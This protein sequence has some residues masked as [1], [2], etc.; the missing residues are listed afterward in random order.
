MLYDSCWWNPKQMHGDCG[1]FPVK[2][3]GV[4]V[5]TDFVV[6]ESPRVKGKE[7]EKD[8]L[9]LGRPF[10]RSTLMVVN[11]HTRTCTIEVQG[12]PRELKA[13][14]SPLYSISQVDSRKFIG[15]H[16]GPLYIHTYQQGRKRAAPTRGTTKFQSTY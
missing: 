13:Y 9:L 7:M 11:L 16:T 1:S 6:V 8:M 12:K 14:S 15:A 2:L 3:D 5:M 4:T 10:I